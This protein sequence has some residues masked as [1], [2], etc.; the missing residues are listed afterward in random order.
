MKIRILKPWGM[1]PPG[2]IIEEGGGV[3][4]LLFRRGLA[5]EVKPEPKKPKAKARA[6]ATA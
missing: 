4:D 6:K 1:Y 5:E 3:C 2:S